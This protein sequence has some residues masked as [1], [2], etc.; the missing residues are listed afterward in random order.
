MV[1]S[2]EL[3]NEDVFSNLEANGCY[4]HGYVVRGFAFISLLKDWGNID[5]LPLVSNLALFQ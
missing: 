2:G 1:S 3:H 5:C 4:G